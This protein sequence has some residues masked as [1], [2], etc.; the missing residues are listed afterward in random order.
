MVAV[1]VIERLLV[2]V[3]YRGKD[4]SATTKTQDGLTEYVPKLSQ[5]ISSVLLTIDQSLGT[6]LMTQTKPVNGKFE[7]TL[8]DQSKILCRGQK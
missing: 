1:C 6:Y 7:H 3:P 8:S 4:K 2:N 5:Y